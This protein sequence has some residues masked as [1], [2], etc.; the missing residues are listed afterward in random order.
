MRE[1]GAGVERENFA[2]LFLVATGF[3]EFPFGNCERAE[4]MFLF[5]ATVNGE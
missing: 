1:E 4:F 2:R 5:E 3:I